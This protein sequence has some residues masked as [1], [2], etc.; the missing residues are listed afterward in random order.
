M[1][2]RSFIL[3][4]ICEE[5]VAFELENFVEVAENTSKDFVNYDSN[6]IKILQLDSLLELQLCEDFHPMVVVLNY[7]NKFF[8]VGVDSV[9]DTISIDESNIKTVSDIIASPKSIV[10]EVI[11]KNSDIIKIISLPFLTDISDIK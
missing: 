1:S 7:K 4:G 2:E 10:S 8:A 11:V 3:F 9:L 6:D 5:I